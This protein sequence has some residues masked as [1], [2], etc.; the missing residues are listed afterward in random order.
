[1][2]L[3]F[4]GSGCGGDS[5]KVPAADVN[6]TPETQPSPVTAWT[7]RLGSQGGFTG[8]GSGH[9]IH[10]GGKVQAWSQI[11]PGDTISVEVIGQAEPESLQ[12]L[13]RAISDPALGAVNQQE[14]GNMTTFMEWTRT[15]EYRRWS[16]PESY[17]KPQLAPPLQRAYR[18][19]LGA[20]ASARRR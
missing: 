8:G 17:D 15:S 9:F 20:V 2:A 6:K 12:A 4:G 1:L 10:S 7:V 13:E 14:F 5:D 16:W 3:V 19:A 11:V 18:A